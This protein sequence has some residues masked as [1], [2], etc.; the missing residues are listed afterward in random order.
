MDNI[1]FSAYAKNELSKMS[2]LKNKEEVYSEF[3]GYCSSANLVES[4]KSFKFSTE[5]EY[6]INRFAKL[7][8]NINMNDYKIEIQ[9]KTFIITVKE[10]LPS[11]NITK[12]FGKNENLK[13]AYIRGAFLGSGYINNP[14]NKYHL[15]VIF[16]QNEYA[17]IALNILNEFGIKASLLR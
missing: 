9:G 1:S 3:L 17:G 13:K 2:N 5:N 8:N 7:L 16:K 15:E 6:N 12:E 4:T 14:E 11:V 10:K